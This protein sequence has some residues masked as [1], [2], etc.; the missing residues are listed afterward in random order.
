MKGE[1]KTSFF[2]KIFGQKS[3]CCSL[4][5][6]EIDSHESKSSTQKDV[7]PSCCLSTTNPDV[8]KDKN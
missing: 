8:K 3:S 1:K 4:D 5:I 6:E 7:L 2:N